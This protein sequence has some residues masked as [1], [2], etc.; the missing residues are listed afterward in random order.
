MPAIQ[1]TPVIE[2]P[3]VNKWVSHTNRRDVSGRP[4][5]FSETNHNN[6]YKQPF[7]LSFETRYLTKVSGLSFAWYGTLLTKEIP[8]LAQ[9]ARASLKG[10]TPLRR[11]HLFGVSVL[12]L[13]IGKSRA[14][15]L[16]NRV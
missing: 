10:A 7:S 5:C 1:N 9:P 6:N 12:Q 2:G 8:P 13:S 14:M 16:F 4:F 15:K 3:M 11:C